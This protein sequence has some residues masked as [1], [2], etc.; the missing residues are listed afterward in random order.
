MPDVSCRII[1]DL[2]QFAR[3]KGYVIPTSNA[4][5]SD[6]FV[7]NKRNYV[8]WNFLTMTCD[9][10]SAKHG[11]EGWALAYAHESLM[12]PG[13]HLTSLR[14]IGPLLFSPNALYKALEWMV[15][16]NFR[17]VKMTCREIGANVVELNAELSMSVPDYPLHF[18]IG[19]HTLEKLPGIIGL[20]DALVEMKLRDHG[21]TL[22]VKLPQSRS[23][24]SRFQRATR[25]L[26]FPDKVLLDIK[27]QDQQLQDSYREVLEY[28]AAMEKLHRDLELTVEQR[29][30]ELQLKVNELITAKVAAEEASRTKSVFLANISHEL[31]TPLTGIVGIAGLLADPH[32][33]SDEHDQYV[34]IIGNS[35]EQLLT[36][37]DDLLDVAK[38]EES[39]LDVRLQQCDPAKVVAEVARLMRPVAVAK[40]LEFRLEG[41]EILSD[42]ITSDP[43]RL[44]Q[45]LVN[46]LGNAIK[47][48][49]SGFIQLRCGIA[50]H[51]TARWVEFEIADSGKGISE[52]HRHLLFKPFSQVDSSTTRSQGGSGLGL[53]LSKSLANLLGGDL[54]LQRS[55]SGRGSVFLVKIGD[56]S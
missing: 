38:H 32:L 14:M 1:Q 4:S 56:L 13:P 12:R 35:A 46:V 2:Q 30:R 5:I 28:Q 52:G 43:G 3:D 21:A 45:I 26:F 47:F 23:I 37:I 33:N 6:A 10:I 34:D 17:C 48:T 39:G 49:E 31:R 27:E 29:T 36:L 11:G 25:A 41:M 50:T 55:E 53:Y 19:M 24:V 42:K 51:E 20:P 9:A 15:P 22:T 54:T 18:L 40:G 16:S 44:R 8:P 7:Q